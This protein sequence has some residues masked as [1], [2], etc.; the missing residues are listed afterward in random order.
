M[1]RSSALDVRQQ[2][3]SSFN[4]NPKCPEQHRQTRQKIFFADYF[5]QGYDYPQRR[6]A[7]RH[8]HMRVHLQ[9]LLILKKLEVE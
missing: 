5:E 4:R 6:C 8:V 3:F 7:I 1:L 9:L 2:I